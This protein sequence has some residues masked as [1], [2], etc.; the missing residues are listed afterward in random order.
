MK[1]VTHCAF[2]ALLLGLA[3]CGGGGGSS[4]TVAV[5]G[6][7]VV[8]PPAAPTPPAVPA[9]AP[10]DPARTTAVARNYTADARAVGASLELSNARVTGSSA[11]GGET[12]TLV[13]ND[14]SAS[15]RAPTTGSVTGTRAASPPGGRIYTS[16]NRAQS[17]TSAIGV[18]DLQYARLGLVNT[19]RVRSTNGRGSGTVETR[20]AYT[21]GAVRPNAPRPTGTVNGR[22]T[23][24][25]G[26][27]GSA[28]GRDVEDVSGTTV[29]NADFDRGTISG[30]VSDLET[31]AGNAG[32][33]DL[34]LRNGRIDGNEYRGNVR[35]VRSGT[36]IEALDSATRSS[37]EGGFYGPRAQETV[38]TVDV[39]GRSRGRNVDI[40]GSY[41]AE[42]AAPPRVTP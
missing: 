10:A 21:R 24:T 3:G 22:A 26:L 16:D 28:I 13:A 19:T 36:G 11:R 35:V 42:T 30:E 33:V 23:Y 5:P 31:G 39:Q 7:G 27:V 15:Y 6:P 29:L 12:A 41:A 37:F 14:R 4:T 9:P 1:H 17:S 20:V 32:T 40:I 8:P 34:Q 25:G 2:A 18:V 38:G